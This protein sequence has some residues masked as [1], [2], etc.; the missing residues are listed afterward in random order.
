[1][2]LAGKKKKLIDTGTK[3]IIDMMP[4][5]L[6]SISKFPKHLL[7]TYDIYWNSKKTGFIGK[8]GHE[9]LFYNSNKIIYDTGKK[10]NAYYMIKR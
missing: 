8:E 6:K 2:E 7:E 4:E 5:H 10:K 9:E 3:F 1:M